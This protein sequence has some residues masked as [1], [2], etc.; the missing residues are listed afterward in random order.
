MRSRKA[1]IVLGTFTVLIG[2]LCAQKPFRLYISLKPYDNVPM[3]VDWQDK[4]E[5]IQ[6]RLMYP[7]HPEARF[8][9]GFGRVGD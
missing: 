1:I 3:P 9:R 7:N 4:A 2:A 6:A 8:A 5:W